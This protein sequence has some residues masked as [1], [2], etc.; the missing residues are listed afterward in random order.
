MRKVYA[1]V[2]L[3]VIT[4]V[5]DS[6]EDVSN[7]IA[8]GVDEWSTWSGELVTFEDVQVEKVEITDSK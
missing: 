1:T 6:I 4:L 7:A 5:D 8:D 3:K 2:T